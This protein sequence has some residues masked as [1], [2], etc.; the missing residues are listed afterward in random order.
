[1]FYYIFLIFFFFL[2]YF[3]KILLYCCENFNKTNES[4]FIYNVIDHFFHF[5]IL[6]LF[7]MLVNLKE[8]LI[9]ILYWYTYTRGVNRDWN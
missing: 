9:L 1:M 8:H 3:F 5:H 2:K 4:S 7:N 6:L